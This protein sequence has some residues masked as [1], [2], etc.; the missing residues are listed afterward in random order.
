MDNDVVTKISG[1]FNIVDNTIHFSEAPFGKVPF[2]NSSGRGDE[3]DYYNIEN[4][5]KFSGRV[6]IR[7]G[8]ENSLT[9]TY[10]NNYIID[11]ISPSFTGF[12][13]EFTLTSENSNI[14]GIVTS[15]AIILINNILQLPSKFTAPIQANQYTLTEVSGIT[16]IT[17]ESNILSNYE[18]DINLTGLPRGGI[19]ISVGST[20]GF[21]YQPLVAAGGTAIVSSAGTIQ[22]VSIGNSGSGYRSGIQSAVNVGVSTSSTGTSSI[23]FIGTAIVSNGNVVSIAITNPGV[24][25]TSSNP[26]IVIFDA[27][28]PYYNI[29]LVYDSVSSGI[30]TGAKVNIIVGQGSSIISFEFSNYGFGYEVGDVLTLDVGGATGI[31]TNSSLSFEKFT[32]T[33]DRIYDDTLYG[34]TVG[35]LK[36]L[37]SVENLIDGNRKLFPIKIDG[38]Q[39]SI[40]SRKGSSIDIQAT[41]LVFINDVLQVPG[42]GYIFNGGSIIEITEA[43]KIGDKLKILFYKGTG[44]VDT[45]NVDILEPVEIGDIVNINSNNLLLDEK[46]RLVENIINTDLITTSSYFDVGIS[47]DTTLNRPITLCK[48]TEDRF[49]SGSYVSK[50]RTTYEPLIFPSTNIIENVSTSSTIIFV[51]SVK[52]FFDSSKEYIQNNIDNIPQ[53][54]IRIVSQ[55]NTSVAIAT[56]VVSSAGTITSIKISDGGI[57]Y[58]TNPSVIIQNPVGYGFTVGIGTTALA[59]SLISIGGTVSSVSIINPGSGYTSSNPP[60]VII[61]HPPTVYEDITNISYS[62]DFGIIVGV[63]TTSIVGVASTGI[64]FDLFV[65]P[66]SYLRNTSINVGIATTGISGIQTNY[67]FVVS[68]SNIGKG[69]TSL[70]SSGSVVGVGSTFLDNIYSAVKVSTAQTSVPGIGI[71]YVSRVVVSVQSY[72]GL[73]G[74]GY[75]QFFGNYSWGLISNMTRKNPKSFSANKNGYTGISS[76]PIVIRNKSLKYIGYSTT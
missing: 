16:S 15:N 52:T 7:S 74:I 29:P 36:V 53:K 4:K 70:N 59:S 44:D 41:L 18:S 2:S 5:S 61:E 31:P 47:S 66:S 23:H 22:S 27:P 71:T 17:F 33:V 24:G 35:D 25:Y 9:E 30:G 67:L 50:S 51:E 39:V 12:T 10:K 73:T 11:S 72:N 48:Q 19:I 21:G 62:G 46:E 14:S 63:A 38:Q 75:S 65:P 69:V 64:V 6:F 60:L 37:D 28:L 56:A 42:E 43:P 76:S 40:R 13:S 57:G 3:E 32:L 34:W 58:S 49:I 45:Q 54:S 8:I 26:P 55:N 20:E 1:Q 68:N